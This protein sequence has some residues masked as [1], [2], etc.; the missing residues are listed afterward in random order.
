MNRRGFLSV[1]LSGVAGLGA[2]LASIPFVRSLLPSARAEA[3][4]NPVEVDLTA[5]KPG[6]IGAYLYRGRT[7]L[8]LRRTEQM[9]ERLAETEGR[10]IDDGARD[11]GTRADPEYVSGP[12]RSVD[13]EYLVVEGVCTHLGCVPQIKSQGEG[14]SVMGDWWAG[15]LICP[16][17]QSGFDYAGRVI[18]GPAPRNLPVPPHRFVA[19][20]RLVIGESPRAT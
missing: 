13:P 7:M 2:F 9:L 11:D 1:A 6:Q 12:H 20:G 3:L 5:L 18:K 15:G 10:L 16:C 14:R 19:S 4:G 17:H 8:V